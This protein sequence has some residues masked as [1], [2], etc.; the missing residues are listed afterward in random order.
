MLDAKLLSSKGVDLPADRDGFDLHSDAFK[1]HTAPIQAE[2]AVAEQNITLC[3]AH[4]AG[5]RL[6]LRFASGRVTQF[7]TG[8]RRGRALS[9]K[10]MPIQRRHKQI[11]G[12]MMNVQNLTPRRADH[13]IDA[14]FTE[15]WSPRSF[16]AAAVSEAEILPLFEAARWAPSASNNQPWRFAYGLRGDAGFAKIADGLVPFNRAWA[17]KA[18]ALVVV[19]SRSTVLRDGVENPNP[20]HVFDA[21][22]SWMAFA[23]QAHLSGLAAHAMGGFD[24]Q[25]LAENLAVPQGYVLHAVI[26]VGHRGDPSSLPEGLQAREAPSPRLPLSQIVGR[27]GFV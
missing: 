17:E 13:A 6:H 20:W 9:A 25:I 19:A 18:A 15:R 4:M 2:I 12:M 11:Q 21:G 14:Q 7:C 10:G 5:Y 16:T 27:G 24:A 26:A 1:G 22:S 3:F 8:H 23:L